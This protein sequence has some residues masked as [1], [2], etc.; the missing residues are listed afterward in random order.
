MSADITKKDSCRACGGSD[1]AMIL[2]LGQMSPANSFLKKED[3]DK[4]EKKFPLV[5]YFCKKCNLLQLLDVVAKEHLYSY[6]DYMTS[7][8]QPLIDHFVSYGKTIADNFINSPEDLVVE[9]GGNDGV[10]LGSMKDLCR[11]LNIEPATNIAEI[12]SQRG[13]NTI[14]NF[15][16]KGLVDKIIDDYGKAKVVVANNV[17]AHINDLSELFQ[18]VKSLLTSDGVFIF[19]VHWVGN[20]VGEG[21]FDQ[22]Y[23]EHL[24]YFSLFSLRQLTRAMGL[25]VFDV[26]LLPMHGQSLRVYVG[27]N[28]PASKSVE[29]IIGLE[30]SVGLYQIETYFK[31]AKKVKKTKEDL[32]ELL[33][34]LKSENKSISG[35][36][37][38]AKG[39]TLLNYC[40][41]DNKT[42]DFIIDSTPFKQ[43][44]YTPGSHIPVYHPDE[45]HKRKPDVAL[46]LAWNYA[47]I[48]LA[49]EKEYRQFGGKFIIPVPQVKLI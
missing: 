14:N 18:G 22:I 4:P 6:Y 38:P 45:F 37:A 19:E 28:R 12:A 31:F 17:V 2:D 46:L 21:G 49:K 24:C 23:H 27:L 41:V 44:L 1:F 10:L 34:K 26:N 3:L 33:S 11:V 36:G 29:E 35:Y 16:S 8:S 15:F 9:I 47:D 48:I 32:R 5:V 40:E 39:N 43:G 20:L 13:V 42:I 25:Q 30:K 7:A